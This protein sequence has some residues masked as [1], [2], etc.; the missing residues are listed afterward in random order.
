MEEGEQQIRVTAIRDFKDINLKIV[1][2]YCRKSLETYEPAVVGDFL[3][4]KDLSL[5]L[6]IFRYC[7][8]Y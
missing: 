1:Y 2:E 5:F 6:A 3:N 4:A 7:L 8:L